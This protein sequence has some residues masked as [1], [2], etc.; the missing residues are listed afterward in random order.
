MQSSN[1]YSKQKFNLHNQIVKSAVNTAQLTL[2]YKAQAMPLVT[3]VAEAIN[4]E[5]F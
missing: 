4:S 3:P 1:R 5:Y 2:K